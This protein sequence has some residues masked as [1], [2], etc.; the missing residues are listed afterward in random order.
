MTVHDL[1]TALSQ[2]DR[3]AKVTVKNGKLH[4][5]GKLLKVENADADAEGDDE[6]GSDDRD[7]GGE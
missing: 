6:A 1:Y 4:V 7:H 5:G 2:Q 3:G